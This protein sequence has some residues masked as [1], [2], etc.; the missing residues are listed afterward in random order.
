M[1]TMTK[2]KAR[3][4]LREAEA[5]FKKVYMMTGLHGPSRS[6]V[7]TADMEAV[8]KIVDRCIKRIQ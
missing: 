4:R 3:K 1:A 2:A 8:S 6:Y 5:K 7:R